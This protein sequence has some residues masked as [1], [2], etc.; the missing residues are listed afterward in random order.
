MSD[1]KMSDISQTGFELILEGADYCIHQVS[2]VNQDGIDCT[3]EIHSGDI[4]AEYAVNAMN[5]HDRVTEENKML[6]EALELVSN[7]IPMHQNANGGGY[8]IILSD[9]DCRILRETLNISE[10]N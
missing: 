6:R 2:F 9:D 3:N 8:M 1:K 10:L 7:I 4:F 5:L